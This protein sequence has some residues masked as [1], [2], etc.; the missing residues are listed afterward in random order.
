LQA[1]DIV[2]HQ[3]FGNNPPLKPLDQ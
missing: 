2:R 3:I 1:G